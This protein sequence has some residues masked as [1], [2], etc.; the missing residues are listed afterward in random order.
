MCRKRNNGMILP[1][2]V[3]GIFLANDKERAEFLSVYNTS[4]SIDIAPYNHISK[5][6]NDFMA[7]IL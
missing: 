2:K 1:V 5:T 4:V 3:N 6:G 7:K